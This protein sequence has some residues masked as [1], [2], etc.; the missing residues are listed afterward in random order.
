MADSLAETNPLQVRSV[1]EAMV[2]A[3]RHEVGDLLQKVY[4]SVAILKDR[5]PL[6]KE[7]ERG[8]LSRL[9]SRAETCKR[10]LDT[11][12]DFICPVTIDPQPLDLALVAAALA[13]TTRD[14]YPKLDIRTENLG[15]AVVNGDPKR[16]SQVGELLLANACEAA[17][18]RVR[19]RIEAFPQKGE[20]D[21]D[22]SDDGPGV[23]PEQDGQLFTP[24]FT[25]RP[26]HTGLGL[27]LARKLVLLHGGRI[28]AGNSAG[29]GF[30]AQVILPIEPPGQSMG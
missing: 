3:L 9:G 20:V 29:G 14:R 24:F 5:I 6:E 2:R 26:G 19:I 30:H 27:A 28:T 10:V 1:P 13:A 12:H 22:I 16:V 25:T 8:V 7:L 18:S 17:E 23:N 4:A 15:T 21:W 11:A